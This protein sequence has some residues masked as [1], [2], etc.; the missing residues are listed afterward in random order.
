[1]H[2]SESVSI[3]TFLKCIV[4]YLSKISCKAETIAA[5]STENVDK[6]G[7]HL[8]LILIRRKTVIIKIPKKG[9]TF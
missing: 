6:K 3:A 2:K 5:I 9:R 7:E 4:G 1:M 8:I